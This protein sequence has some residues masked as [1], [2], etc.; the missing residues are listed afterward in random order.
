MMN[1]QNSKL[2]SEIIPVEIDFGNRMVGSET[3]QTVASAISVHAGLDPSPASMLVGA[4]TLSGTYATQV[5]DE[6]L[7]GVIYEVTISVRTS[8]NNIYISESLVAVLS[9]NAAVPPGL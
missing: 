2:R 7:P 5:L 8:A 4:P 6:G 1:V 3:P 9:D